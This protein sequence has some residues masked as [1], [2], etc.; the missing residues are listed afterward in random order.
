MRL[1]WLFALVL[2][3]RP[4]TPHE[5]EDVLDAHRT[6]DRYVDAPRT[7]APRRWDIGHWVLYKITTAGRIGYIKHAIVGEGRCGYWL[8]T[9]VVLGPYE[10]RT[11]MKVCLRDMP[12]PRKELD[13][14]TDLLGAYMSRRGLRTTAF[15][16]NNRRREDE[17]DAVVRVLQGFA[18][19]AWRSGDISDRN[20]IEVHAGQFAGVVRMPGRVWLAEEPHGVMIWYHA[21]VPLGGMIKAIAN[22]ADDEIVFKT[23]LLDFGLDGAKSE[24][25]DF[26]EHAK[27]VGLD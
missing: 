15:D 26:T 7:S 22:D 25:P 2:G 9:T 17:K 6:S 24:L 23:E 14:Q 19:F 21:D 13:R 16:F 3:C 20:E 18:I 27:T 5:I 12:D 11:V 1:V 4:G 10:D 8:E